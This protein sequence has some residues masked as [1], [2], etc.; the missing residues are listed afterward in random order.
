MIASARRVRLAAALLL[1]CAASAP[2]GDDDTADGIDRLVLV[3]DEAG[4][5]PQAT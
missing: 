5:Q 3:P 4:D 1:A 2:A